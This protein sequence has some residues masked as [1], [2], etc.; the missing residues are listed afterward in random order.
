[1]ASE[2]ERYSNLVIIKS[3][4]KCFGIGGL[5]L[6]YVLSDNRQ[7]IQKVR[8]NISIWN[9]NGFAE[10]FLRHIP[11]YHSEF[12]LSC[13]MVREVRD[14]LY[15]KLCKVND[16]IVYK[17]SANFV[18]CKIPDHLSGLEIAKQL[19][20]RHNLLVKHCGGKSMPMGDK[21]LRIACR[22]KDDNNIVL[23]ALKEV[24]NEFNTD[25]G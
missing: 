9:I 17:P 13:E 19:F 14:D 21:Y 2:I 12:L 10:A 22:D 18:F 16:L 1:M 5:R 11:R 23:N 6:G 8:E 24:I 15:H 4:S 25:R 3:M 20:I 7:F